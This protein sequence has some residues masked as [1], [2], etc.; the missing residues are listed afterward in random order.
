[1]CIKNNN[2]AQEKLKNG[3]KSKNLD[4][5]SIKENIQNSNFA[6]KISD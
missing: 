3:S 6:N 1:M 5:E 4:K 2:D